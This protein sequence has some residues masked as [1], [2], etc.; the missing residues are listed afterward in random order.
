MVGEL[1][2]LVRF[3]L[4]INGREN[5]IYMVISLIIW[6]VCCMV[7]SFL[8]IPNSLPYFKNPNFNLDS[9]IFS[10]ITFI[11]LMGLLSITLFA[12]R[13]N[14]YRKV[15]ESVPI[16]KDAIL[17]INFIIIFLVCGAFL[18]R[19]LL[20]FI[21]NIFMGSDYYFTAFVGFSISFYCIWFLLI[22]YSVSMSWVSARKGKIAII[23]HIVASTF[24][25]LACT[26]T[27][28]IRINF[29]NTQDIRELSTAGQIITNTIKACRA[30]GGFWGLVVIALSTL[31]GYYICVKL[32]LRQLNN[33]S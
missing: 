30:M 7:L 9:D 27:P 17:K 11:L 2:K 29:G 22:S 32:P 8:A 24:I 18:I 3:Y 15:L 21:L 31:I 14:I 4:D 13:S 23:V 16:R 1:K 20:Y 33:K 10:V 28:L 25:W 26:C 6:G 19:I 5:K 12:F